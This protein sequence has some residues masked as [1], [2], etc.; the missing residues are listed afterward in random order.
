MSVTEYNI[1]SVD[2]SLVV[3]ETFLT[4]PDTRSLADLSRETGIHKT[5]LIR[6]CASLEAGRFLHK[7]ESG[8]YRLGAMVFALGLRFERDMRLHELIV[9]AMQDLLMRVDESV[10]FHVRSGDRRVCLFRIDARHSLLDNVKVGS[11][12]PL[13]KGAPGTVLSAFVN[14]AD[15]DAARAALEAGYAI[16]FGERD[17]DCAA[18]AAPVIGFGDQLLGA[19]SVSGPRIRLTDERIEQMVPHVRSA[20]LYLTDQFAG[21]VPA[22]NGD[23]PRTDRVLFAVPS[24][25]KLSKAV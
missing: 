25:G 14:G 7:E 4:G 13:H 21:R 5:T 9:P 19:I 22:R 8:R 23:A 3:L 18:I 1:N 16:S 6:I 20:A 12:L 15:S 2:R 17:P 24:D 10:S 11:D